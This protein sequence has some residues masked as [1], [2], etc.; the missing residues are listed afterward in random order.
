[1]SNVMESSRVL[2]GQTKSLSSLEHQVSVE[3][4]LCFDP[5]PLKGKVAAAVGEGAGICRPVKE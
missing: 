2:H 4:L 1:M 5:S 3:F